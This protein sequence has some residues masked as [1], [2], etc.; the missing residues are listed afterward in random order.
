MESYQAVQKNSTDQLYLKP[1]MLLGR[2]YPTVNNYLWFPLLHHCLYVVFPYS[3]VHAL[4]KS[5]N[6]GI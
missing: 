1:A 5:G 6:D 2:F 4:L 3:K